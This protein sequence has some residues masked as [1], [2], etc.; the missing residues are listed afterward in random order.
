MTL[1]CE[2]VVVESC[3]AILQIASPPID[4]MQAC[5]STRSTEN[6]ARNCSRCVVER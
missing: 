4:T 1:V 5:I 3:E 6:E 2:V